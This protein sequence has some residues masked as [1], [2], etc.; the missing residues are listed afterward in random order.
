MDF[1]PFPHSPLGSK[2]GLP[3]DACAFMTLC[4]GKKALDC[5]DCVCIFPAKHEKENIPTKSGCKIS[6]PTKHSKHKCD[7]I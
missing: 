4:S 6:N 1:S 2:L 5:L 7:L 3:A